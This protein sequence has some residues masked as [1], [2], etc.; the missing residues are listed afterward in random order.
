MQPLKRELDSVANGKVLIFLKLLAVRCNVLSAGIILKVK[1]ELPVGRSFRLKIK[2]RFPTTFSLPSGLKLCVFFTNK[3]VNLA[4]K[5][6][7]NGFIANQSHYHF[8]LA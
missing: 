1:K 8:S 3:V 4:S 7:E 2:S 5:T 6:Q